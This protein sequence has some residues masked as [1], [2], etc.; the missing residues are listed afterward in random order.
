M[1]TGRVCNIV[2]YSVIWWITTLNERTLAGN[3]VIG[4]A[5]ASFFNF[6][7]SWPRQ[8]GLLDWIFYTEMR[9]FSLFSS[10]PHATK[11]HFGA[12]S[13]MSTSFVPEVAWAYLPRPKCAAVKIDWQLLSPD[14]PYMEVDTTEHAPK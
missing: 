2:V 11:F 10:I 14:L 12:C 13:V 3:G 6:L 4:K 7:S 1:K 9:H 5:P 8:E